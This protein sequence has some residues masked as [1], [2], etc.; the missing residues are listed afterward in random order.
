MIS[1]VLVLGATLLSIASITTCFVRQRRSSPVDELILDSVADVDRALKEQRSARIQELQR[2]LK[3]RNVLPYALL[4]I[5]LFMLAAAFATDRPPPPSL[6]PLT[7]LPAAFFAVAAG[8]SRRRKI[9]SLL[10]AESQSD[11]PPAG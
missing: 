10:D 9:Q 6:A 2:Q 7:L 11:L 1:D 5:A 3:E 4:S 8:A